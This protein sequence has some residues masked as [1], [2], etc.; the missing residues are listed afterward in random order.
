MISIATLMTGINTILLIIAAVLYFK[1]NYVI[2]TM[3]E[4]TTISEFVKE[5]TKEDETSQELAG[6][7]GIEV[8]FG[9]DY[10]EDNEDE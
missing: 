6:G 10:L 9:A 7:T 3:E 1:K 5:H 8:G 4:F 2:M